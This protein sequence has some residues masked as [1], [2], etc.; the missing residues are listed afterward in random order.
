MMRRSSN[1]NSGV[2]DPK[3]GSSQAGS[4]KAGNLGNPYLTRPRGGGPVGPCLGADGSEICNLDESTKQALETGRTRILVAGMVFA[5]AFLTVGWRLVDLG[6]SGLGEAPR[7]ATATKSGDDAS[8]RADIADRNGHVLATTLPTVSLSANPRQVRSPEATAK[9]L[10]R[11]LPELSQA[12][13]LAKLKSGRKFVWL[14]PNLTPTQQYDVNRLGIPGLEFRRAEQRFYPHGSLLSH[15]VGFTGLDNNGLAGIE[16]AF[17]ESLSGTDQRLELSLDLRLQHLLAE[18]LGAAVK[19]FRAIGAAGLILD[20][21]SG[22]IL[23]MASL[24]TFDPAQP[25]TAGD[26]ARFNR[27]TLGVYEMGSVFK[28]FTTAMALDAGVVS[29][30]DGYDVSDPIRISRFTIRDYKPKKKWLSIPEIFI[31]S[32][33]IGT[34]HMAMQGGTDLQQEYLRRLGIL[35]APSLELSEIGHPLV[36]SPW[37]EVNTMTISYGHGLA[38]SPVQVATAVAAVVNGGIYRPATLI[39]Q[40]AAQRPAGKR[41]ISAATSQKMRQLMRLVVTD[42]TGRKADAEGY[43]VGG[44]TGTADKAVGRGYARNA[45]ISSFVGAFPMNNPRYVVF[46]MLDDPKGNKSTHGFATGGW[47]AAPVVGRVVERMGPLVGVQP[48]DTALEDRDSHRLLVRA[49]AKAEEHKLA[50][51]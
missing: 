26:D 31:L 5:L 16:R 36:P 12:Q 33:N 44:K 4:S 10:V 40:S 2:R 42:G 50:F 22:E 25:A 15:S 29:L 32:S 6:I 3:A 1:R 45:R 17:D 23:A 18:E 43:L 38:V 28:I 13:V 51:N 7:M 48:A 41:V 21:D 9:Q 24:P 35:R 19:G 39:K 49:M 46:V 8:F 14:K 30:D 20:A 34:V 27:A 37:S 11:I 47:T